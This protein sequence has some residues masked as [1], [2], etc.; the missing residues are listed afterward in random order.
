M[1][2]SK[3]SAIEDPRAGQGT[4][5]RTLLVVDDVADIRETVA[6]LLELQ[7]YQ[8]FTAGNGRE[9]LL[10]LA[11][12]ARP[13]VVLLDL[14]MPSMD[15]RSFLEM[16]SAQGMQALF[17]VIVI[18]AGRDSLEGLQVKEILRKPFEIGTL[19]DALARHAP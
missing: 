10:M 5:A 15:G 11:H 2:S 12:I 19:L 3:I 8:V 1:S 18:T 17:P 6:E 4:G 14:N 7:G 16:L 9:A 13:C